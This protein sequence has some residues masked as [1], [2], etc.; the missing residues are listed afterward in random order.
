M[1][2]KTKFGILAVILLIG[3][4]LTIAPASATYDRYKA[5]QYMDAHTFSYNSAYK[6][7]SG[8]DCT[9]F[10]SQIL[11]A[12][13]W[14]EIGKYYYWSDD[15]WYYDGSGSPWVSSTW[16]NV[17]SLYNF[18]S[19]HSDRA[20]LVSLASYPW[21]T[22]LDVGDIVQIDYHD[23]YGNN[24]PDGKWDH[25]FIV[26]R[27]VLGVGDDLILAAHDEDTNSRSVS[28]LKRDY[29]SANL[30]GWHIK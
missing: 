14:T 12:G 22:K 6:D 26:Y 29:P 19:R 17:G 2:T 30:I 25:T 15:A 5:K 10:A 1:N 11:F 23:T 28:S 9:N 21:S 16:I 7:W 13:G 20:T 24:V 18:M 8:T 4:L 3:S 27:V